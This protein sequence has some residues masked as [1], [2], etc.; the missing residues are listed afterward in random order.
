MSP[1]LAQKAWKVPLSRAMRHA[2]TLSN[3]GCL[4][5]MSARLNRQCII[6]F[7]T[8]WFERDLFEL[9]YAARLNRGTGLYFG[10]RP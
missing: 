6:E 1:R 8:I 10:W 2:R 3:S 9:G 7:I 5:C 4:Q